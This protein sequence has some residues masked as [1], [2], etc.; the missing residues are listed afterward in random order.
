MYIL[1]SGTPDLYMYDGKE[2]PDMLAMMDEYTMRNQK[3]LLLHVS[4]GLHEINSIENRPTND[5]S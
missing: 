3:Y 2:L 1:L 5:P 4:G